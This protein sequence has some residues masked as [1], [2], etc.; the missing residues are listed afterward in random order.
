MQ[1]TIQHNG[2]AFQ[3]NLL[4]P[5][6][7]SIPLKAENNLNAW[8]VAPPKIK[9]VSAD[10]WVGSVA[11]GADVNFNVIEFSPHAH[12]THTECV[13]HITEEAQS[14]NQSLKQFFFIAEV[15]TIVPG[16]VEDDFVITKKQLENALQGKKPQ[17]LVLRTLPND[18]SK[19]HKQYSH[20]NWPYLLEE[21]AAYLCTIGVEHLL[22]DL[23]SVDKE[24]DGGNL[25]AHNAFWNTSG[26]TRIQA[27]ITEFIFVPNK[28]ADGCYLLNLQMASIENN[29][30]PS[31]PLLFKLLKK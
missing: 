29:A 9:P 21:A 19:L 3:A 11:Q 1:I 12:C 23:P 2:K 27:T 28:V 10:G 5:I 17:A 25:L 26:K 30:S 22:I 13:G 18:S 14:V 15:I 8:Y 4:E 31:R 6:D 7:I 20:T 16:K 24:K